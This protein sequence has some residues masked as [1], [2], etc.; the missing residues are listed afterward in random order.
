MKTKFI[1][2]VITCL[3]IATGI[4]SSTSAWSQTSEEAL[5][6]FEN[7][8]YVTALAGFRL[9]ADLGDPDAQSFLGMMY[10]L[11]WGVPQDKTEA[12][13]WYRLAADQ[14]NPIAQRE[15]EK[16]PAFQNELG[17]NY[18]D[19]IGVPQDDAKAI[20]W[21]TLA[22]EQGFADAQFNL[23]FMYMEGRG[24]L[25][26]F[27]IAHMWSNLASAQGHAGGKQNRD[28]LAASMSADQI[29]EA[30][31]LARDWTPVD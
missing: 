8:D 25:Q 19:G 26:D 9:N 28:L 5:K 31:R 20:H 12:V 29:A 30:Q 10:A 11:G 6:A 15:L 16:M 2:V 1:P 4:A 14:G 21:Y 27:A 17:T 24:V 13:R 7:R 22:A 18:A 23:G 3:A